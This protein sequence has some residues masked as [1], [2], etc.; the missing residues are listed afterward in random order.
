M[1]TRRKLRY[2]TK[3][4]ATHNQSDPTL[5]H[6]TSYK[7]DL[8]IES[9]Q[10][11]GKS[12]VRGTILN[13]SESFSFQERLNKNGFGYRSPWSRTSS[14][15]LIRATLRPVY[16]WASMIDFEQQHQRLYQFWSIGVGTHFWSY[17]LALMGNLSNFITVISLVTS[18]HWHWRSV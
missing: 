7:P 12:Q 3:D 8:F 18:Q 17:S 5:N 15:P 9:M 2:Q 6:S 14:Q 10:G 11:K 13:V 16:L 4:G 1:P